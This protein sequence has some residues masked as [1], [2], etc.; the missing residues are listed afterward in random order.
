MGR[1]VYSSLKMFL[2]EE[3][4]SVFTRTNTVKNYLNLSIYLILNNLKPNP[5]QNCDILGTD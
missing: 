5:M 2:K 1:S 3:R 4:N